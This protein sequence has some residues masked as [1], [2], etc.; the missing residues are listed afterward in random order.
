MLYLFAR[1]FFTFE[2]DFAL[3]IVYFIARR[4]HFQRK[5]DL[6]LGCEARALLVVRLRC[7]SRSY[8]KKRVE[9]YGAE[10]PHVGR[11]YFALKAQH[12]RGWDSD[13]V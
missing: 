7:V 11:G 9:S 3:E 1:A 13:R 10:T 2:F 8:E 12:L 5:G 4:N 6:D